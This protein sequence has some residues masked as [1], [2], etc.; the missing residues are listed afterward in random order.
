MRN[1]RHSEVS[2]GAQIDDGKQ[3]PHEALINDARPPLVRVSQSEH[4]LNGDETDD[5]R[6][7]C[8]IQ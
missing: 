3:N 7:A 1:N 4:N 6:R 8:A 2:P 5:P